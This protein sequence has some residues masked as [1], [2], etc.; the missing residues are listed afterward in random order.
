MKFKKILRILLNVIFWCFTGAIAAL[1]ALILIY[2]NDLPDYKKLATY[3]PPVATRLYASDG[4]LLIEYAEERRVFIDYADMP[5]QLVNAFIAAE[6]QNFWTHPGI[7][8]QGIIRAA[9]NNVMRMMGFNT[10]FSGASTITQQVAKNFFLTSE[11]TISRKIKEA[12][13]ALRLERAFSKQHIMTLYLNQIFLGA[14]AYG[15]GSA[16]LMYFNKP[17]SELSLAQCAFL[18]SLPKAP[19]NRNMA[20]ERRNYVLRRMV[21]EGFITQDEADTA[22]AEELNINSGFTAQM[23]EDF[24]YFAEDVRRQ[25]LNSLGRETLYNQGLYI[26]TTIVPELQRAAAA[27]LNKELDVFN[28]GRTEKLQGAIIAM[29]PHTG[30]I[31]AMTGGRSFNESSFNRATQAYRQVG[32]TIKPFVYLAALERGYSPQSILLDAPIVGWREDNTLWKPENYDKKFLGDVPLRLSL[33]TSRNVPTVRLVQTVGERDSIEVAQRFGVYP[34]DMKNINLSMALG[35]GETTLE[36]LV[37]GY[38]A[39][40]N[41]GHAIQPKLVDYIEDRYGRVIGGNETE[42]IEWDAELLP[43]TV[44]ETAEPL[45]DPQSLYQMVSILQG[46]VERGTGKQARVPGHTI[47]GKTGTTNDVKDVWFVGFTKDLIAGVYLGYDTPKSLGRGAGSHMA[48]R[49][50]ADFMRVALADKKDQPFPVPNGMTFMRVNRRTGVAASADPTGTIIS[51]A[52]KP[53]QKPNPAPQTM[54]V[55]TT[56]GTSVSVPTSVPMVGGVF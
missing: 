11:R 2:G 17:V 25:L 46:A 51:E 24:Q 55:P 14:R 4:S 28:Q 30:R 43:P 1:A 23:E 13:L 35:S 8:V 40:V 34:A 10:R 12:I 3:A 38:S 48:A 36:K 33:E 45:S 22:A 18:A 44:A 31:L 26:K 39:F 47:A 20:V 19:N 52:F 5:P 50:F 29:N 16:A 7:D 32:S 54:V 41:G 15:V 9:T 6:D 49:V 53:G 56:S 37:L 27:A 42:I 21:E